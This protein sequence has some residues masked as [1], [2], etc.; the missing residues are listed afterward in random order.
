MII[1]FMTNWQLTDTIWYPFW[2]SVRYS[3]NRYQVWK[4]QFYSHKK[5]KTI[6]PDRISTQEIGSFHLG[7]KTLGT[8]LHMYVL[9]RSY[10]F[11]DAAADKKQKW[12]YFLPRDV[13]RTETLRVSKYLLNRIIVSPFLSSKHPFVKLNARYM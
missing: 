11:D 2:I 4:N 6:T 1:H 8:Y 5:V 12:K 7:E 3:T 10:K 13:S 9:I